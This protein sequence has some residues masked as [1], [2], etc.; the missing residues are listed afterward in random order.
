M[1]LRW[2]INAPAL[3]ERERAHV[4]PPGRA[5]LERRDL[6]VALQRPR[7]VVEAVQER[8]ALERVDLEPYAQAVRMGHLLRLEIDRQLVPLRDR[9]AHARELVGRQDDRQEP[10]LDGV[11]PEDVAERRGDHDVEA[12]VVERPRRVLAGRAAA[13]VP[14]GDEDAS[15]VV[16]RPPQLELGVL[17]PVVEEELAVPGALDALEELL[18]DDLV[19]VDVGPVE[20]G[21]ATLDAA[22]LPH[23]ASASGASSRTSVKRPV[24]AAAAAIV[25]DTRCVRPPAPCRPSKLRFDVEAQRSPG[26]RMSG[27][28]PRH[29]EQPARR[30]S[31]PA[32]VNTSSRPS[33]SACRFT[34]AEP[35]TTIARTP[36]ATRRPAT[37]AAAAR[38]SSIRAFVH[39]PTNTRSIAMSAIAVPGVRSMYRSARSNASRSAGSSTSA[40]SGMTSSIDTT[41][42]G[43]VP[44]VTCGF[45]SVTS[46]S[47]TRSNSASSS[48]RSSRQRSSARSHSA[49]RG[50]P[51]RPSRYAN[52]VSSGAIIP[53]RAPASIDMLQIVIRP[54]IESC[55]TDSPAYSNTWPTPPATPSRPIAPSTMSFA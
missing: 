12:V 5:R 2:S 30:H 18:R 55:A 39:E 19:G 53:A 35:G 16:L 7:D 6:V 42:P 50:T 49:P 25:G 23:T 22:Q 43:F 32:R 3:L 31:N 20:Y 28:I 33:S 17:H 51:G 44:H 8:L 24:I 54:S 37:T 46:I 26:A 14:A 34:W 9:L 41:M 27:F 21:N 11:R 29:I 13:E 38:R 4:E 52:V 47:S 45:N 1:R 15:A 40:G 48:V 36:S 10:G